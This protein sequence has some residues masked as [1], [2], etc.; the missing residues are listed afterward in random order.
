MAALR[1]SPTTSVSPG[2]IVETIVTQTLSVKARPTVGTR[3]ALRIQDRFEKLGPAERKLA[4]LLLKRAD[5]LLTSSAIELAGLAGVLKATAARQFQSLC[6]RDVNEVRL[7]AREERNRTAPVQ[8]V[9]FPA[10]RGGR[11]SIAG[12]RRAETELVTRTFEELRSDRVREL[13]AT[14]AKAPRVWILGLAGEDGR[15]R[16]ARS[17]SRRS[18][19]T[20]ICLAAMSGAGPRTSR[21]P[22]PARRRWS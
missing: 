16:H 18:A 19:A 11:A 1:R 17:C 7:Q 12:H 6:D 21:S 15:A 10:G 4:T 5:D 8:R 13:A 20:C 22:A 14:L 3:L 9:A 2:A